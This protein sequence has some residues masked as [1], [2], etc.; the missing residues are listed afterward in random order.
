MKSI[1]F[2]PFEIYSERKLLIIGAIVTI[3]GS[4]IASYF[5]VRYDG[6]IDLHFV[7]NTTLHQ[8]FI[9]NI[10]NIIAIFIPLFIVGKLINNKTRIIDIITVI[11]ISRIPFYIVPLFNIN[12]IIFNATK[13]LLNLNTNKGIAQVTS[14][15]WLIIIMSAV[16]AITALIWLITLLYNGY[17]IATNAKGKKT[18]FLFIVGLL[19][20]EIVSK[21]FITKFL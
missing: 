21:I 12:N 15:E 2:K 10:I 19:L 3:L 8:P 9:D 1:L 11:L 5:N 18:V 6:V 13:K 4:I 7:E 20:A 14:I 16:L 17:K